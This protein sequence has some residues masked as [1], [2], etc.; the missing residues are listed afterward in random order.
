MEET[1]F[2]DV[3][4]EWFIETLKTYKD[5]YVYQLENPTQVI[6]WTSEKNICVAGNSLSKSEILELHL[7]Q[8]LFAQEIKG[9]CT[10]RDFKVVR[11]GF[12]DGPV[13]CLVH[14]PG[15]RCAVTN[16]GLTSDL[17]V[18]DLGSDDRDVIRRTGG[19]RG[20]RNVAGSGSR[21]AAQPSSQP[22]VLH[23]A[24]SSDVQLS[25][26][27]SGQ[28]LYK[29]AGPT[30]ADPLTSLQFVSNCVFLASC[31]NGNIYIADTR[32]SAAPQ[33]SPPLQSSP[34]DSVLWWADA[35]SGLEPCCCRVIRLSSSGHATVS[36]LRNQ[37]EAV[38]QAQLNIKTR[39][40]CLNHVRVSWAP[41]LDNCVA[42]SGFD[43]AVQ[44]Y[45]TSCWGTALLEAQPLFQ[46]C[47]HAIA[48]RS[49]DVPVCITSHVWH[50]ER[51]R[52][53]LSAASDGS[54]H[55]WD[56]VDS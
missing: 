12:T 8:R 1:E 22:Q 29:L 10:E 5:L 41:A 40:C 31:C 45:N 3:L 18:W 11:G 35:S 24:W 53:L 20:S 56:W 46:H 16:D 19:I 48:L 44:I 39:C 51:P 21:I 25:N 38:S 47:G 17:Q 52:T 13:C 49:N 37:K 9:L 55:V 34:C 27:T 2:A 54:V 23:G 33:L 15:T 26:V 28:T 43:G 36:D 14:V 30:S 50:P 4:D 32:T 42:V 6:E 7:P